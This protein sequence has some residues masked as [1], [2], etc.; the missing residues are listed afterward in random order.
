MALVLVP[1]E[2]QVLA[3]K[4][5]QVLVLA[6]ALVLAPK[7]VL[8]LAPRVGRELGQGEVQEQELKGKVQGQV[9]E[10]ALMMGQQQKALVQV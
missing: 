9:Q 3:P 7:E 5:V 8:A 2:E 6:M 10:P 4:E 1:K